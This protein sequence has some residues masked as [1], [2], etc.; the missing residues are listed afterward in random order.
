MTDAPATERPRLVIDSWVDVL[1]GWCFLGAKRLER[2]IARS[3]R[4]DDIQIALHTFQLHPE[5]PAGATSTMDYLAQQF[6]TTAAR[7]AEMETPAAEQLGLEGLPYSLDRPIA[8]TR[9]VLRLVHL[10]IHHRVG[11]AYVRAVQQEIFSGNYG[12]FDPT[13][14]V[15][16]GV[17]LGI[18]SVEMREVL[19]SDRY[20]DAM[21]ADREEAVSLGAKGVPFT[22][23]ANRLVFSGSGTVAQYETAI[24][25]AWRHLDDR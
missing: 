4:A 20:A 5:A 16:L 10:A 2:A 8:N 17:A 11:P 23:L 6:G 21:K 22:L 15:S 7:I 25:Q 14:L 19:Q 9:H 3:P 12:I 24:E 18:P 1:C 13:T